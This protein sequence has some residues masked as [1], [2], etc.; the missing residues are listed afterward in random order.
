LHDALYG[1]FAPLDQRRRLFFDLLRGTG[2]DAINQLQRK[3][4]IGVGRQPG[5]QRDHH[6]DRC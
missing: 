5:E 6:D 4:P 1:L 3:R 2:Q